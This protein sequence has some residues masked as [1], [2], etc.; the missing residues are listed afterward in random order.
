MCIQIVAL[1]CKGSSEILFEL[2]IFT[3]FHRHSNISKPTHG[4]NSNAC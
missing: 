1:N 4:H 3:L 2:A